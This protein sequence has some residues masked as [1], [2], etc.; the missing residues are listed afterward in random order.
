MKLVIP[1]AGFGKRLRPHTWSQPKPLV[2]VAGEPMLKHILAPLEGMDIDEYICIV[3]YL[4]GQ[5]E[6][7]MR[8]TYD[9]PLRFVV[10]E[11]LLGQAHAIHLC[12][13]YLDGPTIIL[14]AD[15][16]FEADLAGLEEQDA[17]GVIYVKEVEDP[18]RF[19]VVTL[20]QDELVT[21][22]V[23]KPDTM[24]NRLALIGLYYIRDSAHMIQAIERLMEQQIMTK[25]EFFIAD[26]Y[27]L[28][29]EDGARFRTRPVGAWLDAGKPETV[30]GTN[31]H[32]L[33]S[34]HD[35]SA[36]LDP[37]G[38]Y[39]IVPPVRIDPSADIE[40]SV[41]GP[42][43]TVSADCR[44]RNS[45]V[46]NSIVDQGATVE[47]ALLEASLIGMNASVSGR[48]RGYIVGDSSTVG[49]PIDN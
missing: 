21:G 15:T 44:I 35:N 48:F 4:G 20:N 26:A 10:Q 5:I 12:K 16:I 28:M 27:Q 34:G 40:N 7:Y 8:E 14:F 43:A 47:D 37:K 46:R 38:R 3:G 23:E 49:D 39:L 30:L 13:D 6:A 41:I 33:E 18:R 36:A 22:F 25:G 19:G 11:E 29:I 1:M 24:D 9:V 17:D 2:N 32:L 45:I 31:R 42:H